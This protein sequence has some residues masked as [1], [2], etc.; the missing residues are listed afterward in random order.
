M[1]LAC[2]PLYGEHDFSSFCRRAPNPGGSLVRRVREADWVDGGD[3]TVRFEIEA[4][5]FC[6]QMVRA[7]VGTMVDIGSGKRRA[8]EM[9]GIMRARTGPPPASWLRP[10]GCACGRSVPDTRRPA[11]SAGYGIGSRRATPYAAVEVPARQDGAGSADPVD[12]VAGGAQGLDDLV[13]VAGCG[14]RR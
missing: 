14:T 11:P 1:Q 6:Q 10:T 13:A 12:L 7:L 3:G 2:D 5:S 4:S 8:G 9:T